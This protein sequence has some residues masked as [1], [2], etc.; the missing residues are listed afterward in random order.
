[1]YGFGYTI[2]LTPALSQHPLSGALLLAAVLSAKYIDWD[3]FFDLQDL[4]QDSS[5]WDV[6]K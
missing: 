4:L 6:R 1:L 3:A 2:T 5:D